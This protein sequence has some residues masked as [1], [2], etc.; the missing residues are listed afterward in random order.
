MKPGRSKVD[1]QSTSCGWCVTAA[2]VTYRSLCTH[3]S[4]AL[5]DRGARLSPAARHIAALQVRLADGVT[6]QGLTHAR[7]TENLHDAA[8]CEGLGPLLDHC[9]PGIPQAM[10]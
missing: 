1:Q 3:A 8:N 6:A 9:P 5:R 7:R 2:C 4:N 10:P